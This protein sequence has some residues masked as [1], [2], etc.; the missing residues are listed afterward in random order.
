MVVADFSQI[1][2]RVAALL[3]EDKRMMTSYKEGHDLH[4]ETAAAVLKISPEK[5]TTE[6][7]QMAKAVNFGLLYGQGC[8][9]LSLYAQRSYGISMTEKEAENCRELFFQ[10]YPGI[11]EWQIKTTHLAKSLKMVRTPMGRVRDFEKEEKGYRYTEALNTPIQGGAAEIT[12]CSLIRLEKILDWESAR[13]VNTVHDEIILEVVEDKAKQIATLVE[14]SMKMGFL[15]VFPTS[16]PYLQ[17]L[18]DAKIVKNWGE[19]K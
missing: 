19:A 4:R 7:R 15:D 11:K 3:A 13:I 1:E 2:L 17:N 12:L 9:G 14:H 5:V 10:T 8:K 16:S 6:Q 18:V